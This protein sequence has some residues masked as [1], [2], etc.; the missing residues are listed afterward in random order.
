MNRFRLT[1]IA[2]LLTPALSR[3]AAAACL[4][5]PLPGAANPSGAAIVH[6]QIEI[7][8]PA[9]GALLIDQASEQAI[10][11]WQEFSIGAGE[12]VRF[13]QPSASAA[14]LNRVIGSLSS[15]I[16]GQLLANGRVFLINPQG[17]LFGAGSQVDVGALVAATHD[18]TNEHFLSGD[19]AFAGASTA[20]IFN[21]G[22]LRSGDG[23]FVVLA[24]DHVGNTGRI[25]TSGGDI[26][27]AAGAQWS[28][29]LDAEGLVSL[30]VETAALSEL[31]GVD[32]A[33][34]LVASG[35]VVLLRAALARDL[36]GTAVNNSG[37]IS[38][39]SIAERGGQIF[40]LGSGGDVASSG[41]LEASADAVLHARDG[42]IRTGA[43]D[44]HSIALHAENG[45]VHVGDADTPADLTASGWVDISSTQGSV[46]LHGTV[47]AG[48]FVRI[49]TSSSQ[50]GGDGILV[51]GAI[52]AVGSASL[53]SSNGGIAVQDIVVTG[54]DGEHTSADASIWLHQYSA[55]R[56]D[57]RTGAL[58][59]TSDHGAASIDLYNNQGSLFINGD[60]RVVG[61]GFS[62]SGEGYGYGDDVARLWLSAWN[63]DVDVSGRVDV[64]GNPSSRSYSDET[65]Q[66]QQS[67]GG[68]WL[69]AYGR[70]VRFRAPVAVSGTGWVGAHMHAWGEASEVRLDD[71][72][73]VTAL[74]A[75]E[76]ALAAD[77]SRSTRLFGDAWVSLAASGGGTVSTH[78]VSVSGPNAGLNI[79]ADRV[80][81]HADRNG[82]ALRVF[83]PNGAS[84]SGAS[85]TSYSPSGVERATSSYGQAWAMIYAQG[86]SVADPSILAT[87]N[88]TISGPTAALS[89]LAAH[90]V[91]IAATDGGGSVSVSGTGYRIA[92]DWDHLHNNHVP[93][94][95][96]DD[97]VSTDNDADGDP[98]LASGTSAWGAATL[99]IGGIHP[100]SV[101]SVAG[102]AASSL[103]SD[104]YGPAWAG[105]VH[106][107]G[108]LTVSGQGRAL[109]RVEANGLSVGGA[110]T[111]DASAGAVSGSYRDWAYIDGTDYAIEGQ[112]G[113][114]LTTDAATGAP[115]V[116]GVA[117]YGE[118]RFS[119]E[120]GD[121][122]TAVDL[123]LLRV[124]GN[125]AAAEIAH[126][127]SVH[128]GSVEVLGGRGDKAPQ[129]AEVA[130]FTPLSGGAAID[131]RFTE[132][133]GD[134]N[135]LIIGIDAETRPSTLTIDG[136]V[137]VEG[138]GLVATSL[139]AGTVEIGG[140]VSLQH[141]AG[142]YRSNDPDNASPPDLAA[143]LLD[144][145]SDASA[146]AAIGGLAAD[147]DGLVV[148]NLDIAAAGNVAINA[149]S[150]GQTL[151]GAYVDFSHPAAV[152]E[153]ELG[154]P[155]L[156][157]GPVQI[158]GADIR[159]SFRQD[160]LLQDAVLQASGTLAID[161]G[162][163]ALSAGQVNW[164]GGTINLNA[165]RLD[166]GALT[167]SAVNG[168][169]IA[170]SALSGDRALLRTTGTQGSSVQI[171]ASRLSFGTSITIDSAGALSID[172]S[173]F[174]GASP[175]GAKLAAPAPALRLSALGALSVR[176]SALD[177]GA[178]SLH[179]A[180]LSLSGRI[181]AGAL[182]L[183][184]PGT[185]A[186]QSDNGL[187][188]DAGAIDVVAQS[189]QLG[190][191]TLNIGSGLAA[192]G[193]DATLLSLLPTSLR[194][195]SSAPNAAFIAQL[196]STLGQLSIAGGYLYVQAP[197]AIAQVSTPGDLF[198]HYRPFTDSAAMSV[199]PSTALSAG[200]RTTLAFGGTG[201]TGNIAIAG[202]DPLLP[203]DS[204][205]Y[206]FLTQ[207]EIRGL[208]RIDTSGAVVALGGRVIPPPAPPPPPPQGGST[209]REVQGALTLVQQPAPPA[210]T[211]QPDPAP[212]SGQP[213]NRDEDEDKDDAQ[214]GRG[215]DAAGIDA[216][217]QVDV[218]SGGAET[219]SCE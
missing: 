125:S 14:V 163:A 140:T 190:N 126:R 103:Q 3:W 189:I 82:Q 5:A 114:T 119:F 151:S 73:H 127:G 49:D 117:R 56:A 11:N 20:G 210:S 209:Q 205:S 162:H 187:L 142:S 173:Q 63:G 9:T 175:A 111:V 89:L 45:S 68:A 155:D 65:G 135:L 25:E 191:A 21:A 69:D 19:Y 179:G 15:E 96:G 91:R 51:T 36:L 34:D 31:A 211:G 77:G 17:I 1:P 80:R 83:A 76:Y 99:H 52:H 115:V 197:S 207:G 165:V 217:S 50:G 116:G 180:S 154:H 95:Y 218:T 22:T 54:G 196:N 59:A 178:V 90:D 37:R 38:A 132:V 47:T 40:L 213:D 2:R 176:G 58:W 81:L 29:Y 23:G 7:S 12:S 204:A 212:A 137:R 148:L 216:P 74:A 118:A 147:V 53:Q 198:Y 102:T 32:N 141:T 139:H 177:G 186:S 203:A 152:G 64:V 167:L 181:G 206:V 170:T 6:G 93:G 201:Y 97:A 35:G 26:A 184:S 144:I 109:A 168:L 42:S 27:L 62:T 159:L 71:S 136:D 146:P 108:T 8:S 113:A 157:F 200:G 161:G 87:G 13:N 183:T 41:A 128:L 174:D 44:A 124:R 101:E 149:D 92:G 130:T 158:A 79:L 107:G 75:T 160:S 194:P 122:A 88:L 215:A 188:I 195:A 84:G 98:V 153:P 28:M 123:D 185:I 145:G 100:Y 172:A 121:T 24:A 129:V 120:S 219:L 85:F 193:R 48:D 10:I 134:S 4:L 104:P 30:D 199:A 171:S 112:V 105:D 169:S 46:A 214:S 110:T 16:L 208:E 94:S 192:N 70:T 131:P 39:Q 86:G 133:R 67:L 143:A 61:G 202:A 156:V 182:S 72:L 43:I 18:L 166:A 66:L 150:F 57:I 78:G 106:I 164:Q 60:I 33:G 55:G 138:T